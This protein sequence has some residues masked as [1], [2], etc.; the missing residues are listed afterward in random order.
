MTPK[1]AALLMGL[2]TGTAL[3]GTALAQR[4]Q[5]AM[6]QPKDV[7]LSQGPLESSKAPAESLGVDLLSDPR[8]ADMSLY[9]KN[10]VSG[11]KS[12]WNQQLGEFAASGAAHSAVIRFAVKPDG[13]VSMMRL[14]SPSGDIAFDRAAWRSLRHS[15]P[16]QPLP[17]AFI[18]PALELQVHFQAP[19][20]TPS[21]S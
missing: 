18:G 2:L 4:N 15:A 17:K 13:G 11:L 14:V 10:L 19:Q 1:P 16:F 3:S 8:S 5:A 9:M 21:A 12:S 6:N 20:R 7:Q